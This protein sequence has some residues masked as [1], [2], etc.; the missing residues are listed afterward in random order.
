[1]KTIKLFLSVT[2]LSLF[3]VLIVSCN[4]GPSSPRGFSLPEGDIE[5]G[6]TAIF[7]HS[8]LSCHSIEGLEAEVETV[9]LNIAQ[10]VPLGG[11]TARVTTYA[12]L[13]TSIINPSHQIAR[14]HKSYTTDAQ[15]N[16]VMTNYNNV[17]TVSELID[18]VSYLQPKYEVVPYTYTPYHQYTL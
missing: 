10:R 3:V 13:V 8:C 6:K 14:A 5:K 16:S 15:G 12:E 18:V 4:A 2:L 1:M 9:E 7:R 11:R 17:M